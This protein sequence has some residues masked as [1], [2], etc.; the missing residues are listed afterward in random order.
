[1]SDQRVLPTRRKALSEF[2]PSCLTDFNF[3][4]VDLIEE[5]YRKLYLTV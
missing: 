4:A 3:V 2:L 5:L 1:M